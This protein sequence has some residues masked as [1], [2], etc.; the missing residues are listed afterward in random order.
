MK[1]TDN[2]SNKTA[3]KEEFIAL[4]DA[5]FTKVKTDDKLSK[6]KAVKYQFV[7]F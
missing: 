7:S 6:I 3:K 2:Q 1:Q 5:K 4:R